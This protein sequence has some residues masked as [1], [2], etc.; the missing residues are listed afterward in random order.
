MV[1][2]PKPHKPT[3]NAWLSRTI[4]LGEAHNLMR[5][6]LNDRDRMLLLLFWATGG[7]I[8]EIVE[9]RACDYLPEDPSLRLNNRKQSDKRAVKHVAIKPETA[10]EIA[11]YITSQGLSGTEYLIPGRMRG[12][13]LSIRPARNVVYGA[14]FRAGVLLSSPRDGTMRPLWPHGYRHS[15]ITHLLKAGVDVLTVAQ[16]A[17]HSNIANTQRYAHLITTDRVKAIQGVRF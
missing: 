6:G 12:T 7:R 1:A 8:S 9:L 4:T 10:S 3:T 16:Q 11:D 14:S 17:G 5:A 13:H 15:Y 2:E